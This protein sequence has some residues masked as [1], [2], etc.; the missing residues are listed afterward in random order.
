MN[1]YLYVAGRKPDKPQ[2]S[3]PAKVQ[4]VL[5]GPLVARLEVESPAPGCQTLV[6]QLTAIDGLDALWITN[7]IVRT[8]VR[9][10]NAVYL[11]FPLHVPGG[12]M[13]L[14][15]PWAVIRPEVDQ[16]PGACRN[17]LSVGRWVDVSNDRYGITCATLDA[18]LVEVGAIRM[19]VANPFDPRAWVAKLEPSSTFFFYVMNNYWETNYKADQPG[20]AEF[21]YVLRPHGPWDQAAAIRFGLEASQPLCAVLADAQAPKVGS[22]FSIA[23]AEVLATSVKPSDDGRA[24][25]VRLWNA[26]TRPVQARI[27]WQAVQPRRL[28]RSSPAEEAGA[29][30]DG[31]VDLPPLGIV[32]LRAEL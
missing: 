32:T 2:R 24:L 29:A 25:V 20:P 31:P 17:Y 6:R 15:I 5:P 3:G 27:A 28:T 18:P 23:P 16:L 10:P 14:D 26:G 13:R 22:L 11:A 19:D 9:T 4:V 12:V 1:E 21:R 7:R 8:S 30:V